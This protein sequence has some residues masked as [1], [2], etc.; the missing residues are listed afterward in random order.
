MSYDY[1]QTHENILKSARKHFKRNGFR[2]ASIRTICKDAGVTNGAFYA[3]FSSKEE[4]FGC[5]VRPC[6][7]GLLNLYSS[8]KE[9]FF[10]IKCSEDIIEAFKKSYSSY[11]K[12]ISYICGHKEEFLLL[13]DSGEG[14]GYECFLNTLINEETENTLKFLTVS[15]KFISKKENISENIARLGASFLIMTIF[16][17]LRNDQTADEIVKET[18]VVS[19][20]CIAGYRHTLGIR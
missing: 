14:S 20:Y 10:D 5:I 9:Q 3:H 1:Q 2:N 6:I 19:E 12:A 7:E 17:G 11:E 8:E 16:N 13:L 4:L 15:K 18:S